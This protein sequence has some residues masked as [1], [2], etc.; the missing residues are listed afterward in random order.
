MSNR[1]SNNSR[2]RKGAEVEWQ[3]YRPPDEV[4]QE[5]LID[6]TSI[7]NDFED[8]LAKAL[9]ESHFE[10]EQIQIQNEKQF[11]QKYEE[12]FTRRKELFAEVLFTMKKLMTF[13]QEVKRVF[14]FLDPILQD[15]AEQKIDLLKIEG[16]M[17]SLIFKTIFS[18][19]LKN[20]E[21]LQH[22]ANVILKE[23]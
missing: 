21:C 17:H 22:L 1:K 8:Q 9:Q 20:K 15:F 6:G 5:R 19:R 10:Y 14:E 2:K 12:E 3:D 13:D 4:I 18:L 11:Q 16:E 23:E 7:P